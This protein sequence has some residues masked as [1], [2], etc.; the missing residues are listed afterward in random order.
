ML[1]FFAKLILIFN[2]YT[3]LTMLFIRNNRFT[4]ASQ[5]KLKYLHQHTKYAH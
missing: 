2:L 1:D 3:N 4:A 5:Y